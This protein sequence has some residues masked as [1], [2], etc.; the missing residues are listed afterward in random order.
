MALQEVTELAGPPGAGKTVLCTQ[1]AV[2]AALPVALGG[3]H[4]QCVY[5][6]TEGSFSAE[7]CCTM[8]SA[9]IQHV[10]MGWRRRQK[11]QQQHPQ[12][13]PEAWSV[14]PQDILAGIHVFRVHDAAHLEAVLHGAL[15][16][17]LLHQKQQQ[18]QQQQQQSANLSTICNSIKLVVIDSMAFPYRA[19]DVN[20]DFVARTR[21]L[22]N[23]CHHLTQLALQYNLAVVVVNQMTTKGDLLVPALGESW[24]HAVTTRLLLSSDI[25]GGGVST[26]PHQQQQP[27]RTCRLTKSPRLPSGA[28]NFQIVEAGVRG[29]EYKVNNHNNENK[30]A[31]TTATTITTTNAHSH[32]L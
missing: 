30:R 32:S 14:T 28:A 27:T 31:R 3:V 13:E 4:G 24:A 8:A 21:Q 22:T 16:A 11:Q 25:G 9:L 15:P 6:D 17:L 19:L 7:R 12:D 1:L 26:Q 18:Q 2:N 5:I 29:M 10:Q 23:H 20:S